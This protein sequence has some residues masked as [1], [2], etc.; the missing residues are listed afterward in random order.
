[1]QILQE[2]NS[3]RKKA[4]LVATLHQ[5]G[6]AGAAA[7]LALVKSP[8]GTLS[9]FDPHSPL[10]LYLASLSPSG[11]RTQ[12]ANLER[13]ARLSNGSA[14]SAT[15]GALRFG[16]VEII[17]SK[18]Q[19]L[20]YSAPII[21]GTLSALR[22]VARRAWHLG[23]MKAEDFA[24]IK[25]VR[26]VSAQS[27]KKPA[28]ALS[29]V[30]ISSL[31]QA[32]E[33]D[34]GAGSARDACLITLLYGAGL[35]RDE[36]SRL[37][38]SAYNVRTHELHVVGKGAR[39]RPVFFDDEGARRAINNWLRARGAE[40]GAFLCPVSHTGR[41]RIRQMSGQAIYAALKR[42]ALRAGVSHFS[43]HDLRRSYATQLFDDGADSRL[44]QGLLG[45]SSVATTEKYDLRGEKARRRASRRIKV[46]FRPPRKV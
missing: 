20:G 26:G 7:R 9:G 3:V 36:A 1:M 41:I 23:E 33:R 39:S 29:P 42:L 35:R 10:E 30:E 24:R 8:A 28:R 38:L 27:R 12:A 2:S 5:A 4:N 6:G 19:G 40:P 34:V 21:N 17:R 31:L 25:D 46:P 16:H 37:E 14:L 45:H 32:C 18:L 11:R 15:W 44:V 22:G 13:A 43:P